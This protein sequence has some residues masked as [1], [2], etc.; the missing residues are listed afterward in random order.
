MDFRRILLV[1]VTLACI[2]PITI[3]VVLGVGRLLGAMQDA[4]AAGV[5]DRVA[6]ALAIGWAVNLI[7]LV[8][9]LAMAA[10]GPPNDSSRG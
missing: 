1:L 7:A 5:L 10:L 2:F 3:A 4:A 9:S 6:L 8:L